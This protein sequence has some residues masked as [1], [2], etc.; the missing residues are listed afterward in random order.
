MES[1]VSE[2]KTLAIYPLESDRWG[3]LV[4][5]FG[6]TGADGGCWCM[7]WRFSQKEYNSGDR[8]RNKRALKSLVE[9][10]K[11]IGL[12]AYLGETPVGWCG[13]SPRKNFERLERAR[14][15]KRLDDKPVWSI[16]CFF[17]HPKHRHQGVATALLDSAIQFVAE[18]GAPTLESYPIMDWGEP[19]TLSAAYPGTVEMFQ[20]AGFH[21]VLATE[22]RSG[23]Q[24]RVIMRYDLNS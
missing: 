1:M 15:L 17:I 3:D 9:S 12:L 24:P 2:Q 11:S 13:L 16:V 14:Y 21:K 19:M 5:L 10:G 20:K 8:E 22:A 7:Y 18:Q 4:N 6:K 23:G